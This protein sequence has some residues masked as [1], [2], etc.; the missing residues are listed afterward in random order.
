VLRDAVSVR[1]GVD[2]S[3]TGCS[4]QS[5]LNRSFSKILTQNEFDLKKFH[6]LTLLHGAQ[7]Q[8]AM[9]ILH[10]AVGYAMVA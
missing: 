6:N 5:D 8:D 3:P 1:H 9:I 2:A 10:G 7:P 4:G